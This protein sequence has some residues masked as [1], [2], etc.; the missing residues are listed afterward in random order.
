MMMGGRTPETWWAANKRQDNKLEKCCI[1]LVVYL[2]SKM[3]V[4]DT[5]PDMLQLDT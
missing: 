3:F 2:N 1:R 4:Y 5:V